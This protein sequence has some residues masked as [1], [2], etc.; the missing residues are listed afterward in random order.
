MTC[1][2]CGAP[3]GWVDGQSLERANESKRAAMKEAAA[4]RAALATP[5]VSVERDAE[6]EV[7]QDHGEW[8]EFAAGT[9]GPAELALAEAMHYA[10]QYAADGPVKVFRVARIEVA[11]LAQAGDKE[12][13][14]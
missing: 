14:P 1:E 9:D 10:R 12:Q 4:L 11:A 6:Y 5:P 7:H 8:T 2:F 3:T 13:Q